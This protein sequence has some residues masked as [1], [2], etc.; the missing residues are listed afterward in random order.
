LYYLL[1]S[2]LLDLKRGDEAIAVIREHLMTSYEL[3]RGLDL[4]V[5]HDQAQEAIRL[6]EESLHREYDTRL[7]DWLIN[8][9]Q[10]QG[11]REAHFRWQ[12]KRMQSDPSIDHYIGLRAASEAVGNW[13]IVRPQI[14]EQLNQ[15]QAYEALTLAYLHD[16]DWDL[17]WE[18]LG[19]ASLPQHHHP[20]WVIYRLEFTVAEKTR[21]VRPARAIPVYIKYARAE[22]DIRNRKHY[23]RAAQLLQE[24]QK[25]YHQVDDLDG[26]KRLIADLRTEFKQLPALQDELNKARL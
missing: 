10:Q 7:T 26:W 13:G 12:L 19:K 4:L 25:L 17:A 23:A 20:S 14:V 1:A 5:S 16:E 11:D 2:K 3:Q 15:Q 9:Y 6:A 8:L 24:V 18:T 21:H 22:I